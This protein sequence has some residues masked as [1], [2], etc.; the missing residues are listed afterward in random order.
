MHH[1][2][3]KLCACLRWP[4]RPESHI[5]SRCGPRF[6][7]PENESRVSVSCAP[8]LHGDAVY[9]ADRK[10]TRAPASAASILLRANYSANRHPRPRGRRRLEFGRRDKEIPCPRNGR[11]R[12]AAVEPVLLSFDSPWSDTGRCGFSLRCNA[13]TD[14]FIHIFPTKE[15]LGSFDDPITHCTAAHA[16]EYP[17]GRSSV[18]S[19]TLCV[20]QRFGQGP[21][22]AH[23][24][25]V[26]PAIRLP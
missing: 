18:A 2:I 17:K 4:R 21:S 22:P 11:L 24:L 3:G 12:C 7:P 6:L 25:S 9:P 5:A 15:S 1:I 20:D 19:T 26:R 16:V 8:P 23:I 10:T 13:H 14:A